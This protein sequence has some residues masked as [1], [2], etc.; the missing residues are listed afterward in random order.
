VRNRMK[1]QQLFDQGDFHGPSFFP[2]GMNPSGADPQAIYMRLLL[3]GVQAPNPSSATIIHIG[4]GSYAYAIPWAIRD[5]SS[6]VTVIDPLHEADSFAADV[7]GHLEIDHIDFMCAELRDIKNLN[8]PHKS[9]DY[10]ILHDVFDGS[11]N[12]LQLLKNCAEYLKD[13]GVMSANYSTAPGAISSVIAADMLQFYDR[14][15]PQEYP[16]SAQEVVSLIAQNAHISG[17]IDQEEF[18][19]FMQK[20]G[21]HELRQLIECPT[22]CVDFL[23]VY[24]NAKN[25]G[26]DYVSEVALHD[27]TMN[28]LPEQLVSQ[29]RAVAN[30]D[31]ASL[32]QYVDIMTNREYRQSIFCKS[33][34][35]QQAK[36]GIEL[37][38]ITNDL[39]FYTDMVHVN[40]PA[41]RVYQSSKS[42]LRIFLQQQKLIE[43]LDAV[44]AHSPN[45]VTFGQLLEAIGKHHKRD[46]KNAIIELIS[47]GI[48]RPSLAKN[49]SVDHVSDY[50]QACAWVRLQARQQEQIIN[51]NG[52]VFKLDDFTRLIICKL[53][54][55][56]NL[57]SLADYVGCLVEEGIL[58]FNLSFEGSKDGSLQLRLAIKPHVE[59]TL[60]QLMKN[61][62]LVA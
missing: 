62:I 26:L 3:A 9:A 53:D 39:S 1:Q 32:E 44:I 41:Q 30:D 7:Y 61:G 42:N 19:T 12:D 8:I 47:K 51:R 29:I 17:G 13:D 57:D 5:V 14:S 22:Q 49:D 37:T 50:P 52:H 16:L 20:M 45:G 48:I 33:E 10:I 56:S 43:C 58:P 2:L 59:Q 23:S 24:Q 28:D 34:L 31:T 55:T 40:D 4:I 6:H 11:E 25:A 35:A 60:R 18:K 46:L 38:A 54:G 15:L 21:Q 36:H 27:V